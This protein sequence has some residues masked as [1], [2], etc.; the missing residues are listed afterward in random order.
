MFA[1]IQE[2]LIEIESKV[3]GACKRATRPRSSLKVLAVSKTKPA[4]S[5]L[6]AYYAGQRLFGESYMQE[7]ISKRKQLQALGVQKEQEIFHLDWHF[8]GTLQSS[9]VK[10][11]VGNFSLLHSLDRISLAKKLNEVAKEKKQKVKALV[12]INIHREEN[13]GG[14][15]SKELKSFLHGCNSFDHVSVEGLM[16]IPNYEEQKKNPRKAFSY[17]RELLYMANDGA[18]YKQEIKELSMGMS[19]DYEAA[20]LEG[21]TIVRLGTAIFESRENKHS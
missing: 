16:C 20:I 1:S 2:K 4:K 3:E 12:Q 5:I 11:F 21:S 19:Q 13:K 18:Y 10:D 17:L 6:E 7:A 8:V 15:Y 9:K 14:L